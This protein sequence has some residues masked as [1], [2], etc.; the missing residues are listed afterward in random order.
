LRRG[1]AKQDRSETGD[2][3]SYCFWPHG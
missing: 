2:F 1:M 3:K